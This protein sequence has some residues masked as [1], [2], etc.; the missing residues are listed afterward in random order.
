MEN[1]DDGNAHKPTALT[2]KHHHQG[3]IMAQGQQNTCTSRTGFM[4]WIMHIINISVCSVL[5]VFFGALLVDLLHLYYVKGEVSLLEELAGKAE[6]E[7]SGL[8][9]RDVLEIMG[10]GMKR[11]YELELR[12]S[13]IVIVSLLSSVVCMLVGAIYSVAL[14]ARP[15]LHYAYYLPT[16]AYIGKLFVDG[17][18]V[19][20]FFASR[21]YE[22]N[23]S[24]WEPVVL[25]F[26]TLIVIFIQFIFHLSV[27]IT[28]SKRDK[29]ERSCC[30]PWN[31]TESGD[32]QCC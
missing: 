12:Y 22:V 26:V 28:M 4:A 27:T 11:C 15:R 31:M 10:D 18:V 30:L 32:V 1:G 7:S 6:G 5:A 23:D 21:E 20:Y 19:A 14:L 16:W 13:A 9:F 29:G 8:E 25:S 2:S 17:S 24:P 3:N